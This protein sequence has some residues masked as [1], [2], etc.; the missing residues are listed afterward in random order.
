MSPISLST[1]VLDTAA[2]RPVEGIPVALE[3][4]EGDAW[5]PVAMAVTDPDGRV[6]ELAPEG[7]PLPGGD[8][9]VTFDLLATPATAGGWYPEV[10]IVVTLAEDSGHSHVPLLLAPYGF[11]T[12]RGS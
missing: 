10:S 3:R 8:Y 5:V 11:S 7:D 6:P 1:H 2:G 9:R 4:R 12:Y